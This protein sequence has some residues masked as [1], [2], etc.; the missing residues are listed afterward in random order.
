MFE[1]EDKEGN[2]DGDDKPNIPMYKYTG[3]L[4]RYSSI[5]QTKPRVLYA[6]SNP[7]KLGWKLH[8][9]QGNPTK[10]REREN[11]CS[12]SCGNTWRIGNLYLR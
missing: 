5:M 3:R 11:A 4:R 6:I 7:H 1:E 8:L 9:S 10:E 12:L 2:E